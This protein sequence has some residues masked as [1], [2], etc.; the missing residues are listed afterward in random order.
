VIL[1]SANALDSVAQKLSDEQ[2]TQ[3]IIRKSIA[4]YAG[5][6][7]CP[8]ST[9]RNRRRCEGRSAY[10]RPGGRSPLCYPRDVTP[11]MV[12]RYKRNRR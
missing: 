12:E 8:Y 7:A 5:V 2:I 9:M 11:E 4:S 1:A 3:E 10:S 6:C